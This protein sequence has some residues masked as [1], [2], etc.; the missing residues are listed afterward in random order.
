MVSYDMGWSKRG[1][2]RSYDS[3]NGFGAIIGVK[4]GLVLDYASCNRKCKR[5]DM[6]H[7]PRNHDCRK[8]FWGSAKAMEPHVAQNLVNNSTIL[9]SQNV[10]VGVLIGDDDSS[11][12]AACRATSSHPIVKFSDTNHAA[13]GVT[14][15]LYKIANKRKHKELTKDGIV[16]LHRCFT[17]AMTTNKGN[18][19]AMAR[20]IQCI[21]YHAFNNHSKCGMWCGFV[22]DPENY[23]HTIIP[24]GFHDKE[25]FEALKDIFDRLAAN[26]HKFSA[27][28]SS[29]VNESLNASMASKAP[30][31]RCYSLTASSDYRFASTIAQKN[32]GEHFIE[33]VYKSAAMSPGKHRYRYAQRVQRTVIER[34]RRILS[35]EYKKKRLALKKARTALRRRR[36]DREGVTYQT[37]C[38]LLD[39]PNTEMN[40]NVIDHTNFDLEFDDEQYQSIVFLDLETSGLSKDCDILQIAAKCGKLTFATY[41]NP[42]KPIS[43]AATE[44]NGLTNCQGVLMYYGL[45]VDSV[46]LRL[47]I[48]NLQQW[49]ASLGK[50]CYIATHN[51]SFD[52][53]RLFNAIV[54]C[55]LHD[56]FRDV[57]CG[58]IDTL[59]VIRRLTGRKRKGECTI[60]GLAEWQKVSTAGAHNAE[61]DVNILLKI[62]LSAKITREN[63]VESAKSWEEQTNIWSKGE[64]TRRFLN[65]LIPLKNVVGETIRKKMACASINVNTLQSVFR[66]TGA[67]GIIQLLSH[68]LNGKPIVTSH[69]S[70][71]EKINKWIQDSL[72]EEK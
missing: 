53:P 39:A 36:E 48:S 41:I 16:Y 55:S 30:K 43:A 12:I 23:D 67:A 44:A 49:L 15:K 19:A 5:C 62:L 64:C 52:G 11:T 70:S 13:G 6:G 28:A 65:D 38:T 40:N 33:N 31:S 47:A 61:N 17:Y 59:T 71:L 10:E 3:L 42:K 50:P 24:G 37:N 27:G 45:T 8:N 46:P 1:A 63:L 2:G 69:K 34:R 21:P 66:E 22:K 20:D 54:T 9:K 4:T 56:E 26:A 32:E 51:L 35:P 57:V 14:K 25:L 72:I 58:F 18:S 29:N 60:A 68:K 7:D